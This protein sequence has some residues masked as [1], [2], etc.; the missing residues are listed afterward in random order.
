MKILILN[1]FPPAGIISSKHHLR[2]VE[3]T[4]ITYEEYTISLTKVEAN[5]NSNPLIPMSADPNEFLPLIPAYFL[6]GR[7]LL[8]FSYKDLTDASTSHLTRYDEQQCQTFWK[9]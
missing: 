4:N 5:L 3:S 6:I 9:R 7:P 2:C 1:L 8:A